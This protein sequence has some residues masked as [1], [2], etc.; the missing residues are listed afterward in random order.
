MSAAEKTAT[1]FFHIRRF[2]EAD[3]SEHGG[4]IMARLMARYPQKNERALA[5]FLRGVINSNEYLFLYQE[6]A[7]ALAQQIRTFDLEAE[8]IVQERFVWAEDPE[9]A[10][11]Q[12]CA[13][14]FYDEF[15]RW[16][17]SMQI[18]KIVVEEMTDVP[19]EKIKEKLGRL[20]TAP[21]TFARV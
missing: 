18:T 12:A 14:A 3:L 4:W 2:S 5:T 1:P 8:P 11:H 7:V 20:F 19:H 21:L 10:L 6:H 16:A 9:N 15:L 17:A 13:A